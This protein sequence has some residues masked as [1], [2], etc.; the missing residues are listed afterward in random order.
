ML[1]LFL[2]VWRCFQLLSEFLAKDHVPWVSRQSR[3]SPFKGD[4]E[5]KQGAVHRSS[6]IYLTAKKK[7]RKTSVK[8]PSDECLKWGSLSS[9]EVDGIAHEGRRKEKRKGSIKL[10]L[11]R[12]FHVVETPSVCYHIFHA[13]WQQFWHE[14]RKDHNMLYVTIISRVNRVLL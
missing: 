5:V 7:P 12:M 11:L 2:L 13:M 4:N 6:G 9:N 1:R 3:L 14:Q 10:S 8:K